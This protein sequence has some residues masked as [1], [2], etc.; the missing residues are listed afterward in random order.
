MGV[1]KCCVCCY[2]MDA[3]RSSVEFVIGLSIGMESAS[4]FKEYQHIDRTSE[5]T[6]HPFIQCM[7]AFVC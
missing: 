4:Y 5:S 1:I 2:W 6:I 7:Y 3:T